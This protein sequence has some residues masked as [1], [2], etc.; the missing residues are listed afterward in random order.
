MK[1]IIPSFSERSYLEFDPL[2][3]NSRV[4]IEI[5][6]QT[7]NN[8]GI[9]LYNRDLKSGFG[10]YVSLSVRKGQVD[11]RWVKDRFTR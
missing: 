9:L 10:A 6:F 3:L 11:F 1:I 8:E 2:R 4:N 5:E 7:L